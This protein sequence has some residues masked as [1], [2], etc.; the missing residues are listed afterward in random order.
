MS[1]SSKSNQ[2]SSNEDSSNSKRDSS[3]EESY[4]QE[5]EEGKGSDIIPISTRA[6]QLEFKQENLSKN[7]PNQDLVNL[8]GTTYPNLVTEKNTLTMETLT[9]ILREGAN[10]NSLNCLS[11]KVIT[12]L[13]LCLVSYFR[14][15]RKFSSLFLKTS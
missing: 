4:A 11:D 5:S 3:Q 12:D 9:E 13:A 15:F 2:E 14:N 1:E 10:L 7:I 8:I 6:V